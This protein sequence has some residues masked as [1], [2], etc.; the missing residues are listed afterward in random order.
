MGCLLLLFI[1]LFI[2]SLH[3]GSYFLVYVQLIVTAISVMEP[4]P[5]DPTLLGCGV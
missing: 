4:C 2:F 3:A 1:K 5:M